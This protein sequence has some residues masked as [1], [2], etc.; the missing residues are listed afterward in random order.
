[1]SLSIDSRPIVRIASS[2]ADGSASLRRRLRHLLLRL[3]A[4]PRAEVVHR[5][6]VRDAEE[7]RGERR[8]L[9]AE[10]PDLLEHLQERLRREVLRVVPVADADVEVAVDPVEMD[11]VQLFE[12]LAVALLPARDEIAHM[13]SRL[14]DRP[15]RRLHPPAST[16]KTGPG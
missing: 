15:F 12:R 16:P 2:S 14:V 7:P 11:E 10:A 1:M 5:E 13:L 8:R 4:A 9:P 3:P 6:V